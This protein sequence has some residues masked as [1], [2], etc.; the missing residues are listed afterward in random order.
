MALVVPQTALLVASLRLVPATNDVQEEAVARNVLVF[1]QLE[2]VASLNAAL[3]DLS[4]VLAALASDVLL[5]KPRVCFSSSYPE[6]L[7]GLVVD[8]TSAEDTG[9]CS[10]CQVNL[11]GLEPAEEGCEVVENQQEVLES[12]EGVGQEQEKSSYSL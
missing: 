9:C 3:L 7:I 10:D 4:E 8:C 12:E 2:D 1:S 6:L 5:D 11:L